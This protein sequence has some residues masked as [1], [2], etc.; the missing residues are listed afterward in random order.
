MAI[1]TSPSDALT[2]FRRFLPA[3]SQSLQDMPIQTRLHW[4]LRI[5]TGA[6]FI[7]HGAF[8]IIT[9]DAWLPYFAVANIG[10]ETA[11]PLMRLIGLMD[12]GLGLMILIT[13][14]RSVI[15]W[16]AIWG[17]WTALLRPLAGQGWWE[18][19]ERGGNYGVPFAFLILSGWGRT[20]GDW[21]GRIREQVANEVTIENLKLILR[22]SI[23]LLLIGHGGFGAFMHKQLLLDHYASIGITD[24]LVNPEALGI[25]LGWFEITLGMAVLIKPFRALLIV[26]F[27]WK[28][29][30]ELLY[31]ISGTLIFEFIERA[32]SYAAPLALFVLMTYTT[33]SSRIWWDKQLS[34]LDGFRFL[35]LM[36]GF[37]LVAPMIFIN[38]TFPEGVSGAGEI[39]L[40]LLFVGMLLLAL[41]ITFP[42]IAGRIG[43]SED[44][45]RN[46][47][48]FYFGTIFVVV[49]VGLALKHGVDQ[50]L[51]NFAKRSPG[52]TPSVAAGQ[53]DGRLLEDLQKGGYTIF[54]RHSTKD[55]DHNQLTA[56]DRL[57]LVDGLEHP[58]FTSSL[59]LNEQGRA[60]AWLLGE[61]F[62]RLNIPVGEVSASPACRTLET[63]EIAFGRTDVV[64]DNWI[65]NFPI[66]DSL[67]LDQIRA[68]RLDLLSTPPIRG[69]N[70]VIVAHSGILTE[71]GWKTGATGVTGLLGGVGDVAQS[72]AAIFRHQP[73]FELVTVVT[74]WDF[75]KH[76]PFRDNAF[77]P[78]IK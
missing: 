75:V 44:G 66:G 45:L 30:T 7:G 40:V 41:G 9:K 16:L 8:G 47:V 2:T 57:A 17:L 62:K 35:L 54:L 38:W 76:L 70:R 74:L 49:V 73:D 72:G 3:F 14:R 4:I 22:V 19:L 46:V 52:T 50:N 15:L 24:S 68:A 25:I 12:I 71:L 18:L 59:C 37:A 6:N 63:A 1:L 65:Y 26:I 69:T 39:Q 33:S 27:F 60:E 64:D 67:D 55:K 43:T 29:A 48:L 58:T 11:Y 34:G 23:A 10:P 78:R 42:G 28:V 53:L 20:T 51:Y 61:S 32:G 5:G 13:P 56:F 31:P 21:F 36:F 77:A